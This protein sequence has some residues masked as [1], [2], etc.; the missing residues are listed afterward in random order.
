MCL[1]TVGSSIFIGSAIFLFLTMLLGI[2]LK[3]Y[4]PPC[5]N[6]FHPHAL[7][8]HTVIQHDIQKEKNTIYNQDIKLCFKIQIIEVQCLNLHRKC[9]VCIIT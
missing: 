7:H 8:M 5:A 9:L 1:Q 2:F 4:I 6:P 3:E